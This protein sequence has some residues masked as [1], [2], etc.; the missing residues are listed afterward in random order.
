MFDHIAIAP[1]DLAVLMAYLVAVVLFGLWVG[2]G[3]Q[4]A[5]GYLLGGRNLPWWLL[6]GS[7]VATETSTATFLS[8]PGL[9]FAAPAAK[10][11]ALDPA[12]GGDLRF[13]QLAF[14]MVI[15]RWLIVRLLLPGYFHHQLFTAYQVLET[16]FGSI[17]KVVASLIFLVARNVGDGLR[18]FLAAIVLA[19]VVAVPLPL[20]VVAVGLLTIVY[21]FFG[22]IKSVVWNDC[23]QF[24]V[25]VTG[26]I[27]AV[28]VVLTRLPGGCEQLLSFAESAGKLRLIDG[29]SSL[30]VP[31]TI[32]AGLIGGAFLSL[33]THGTDQIMVQRYL[34]AR[35]QRQAGRALLLSGL[36]VVAQFALFLLLGVA[37]AAY[38]HQFPPAA[39]FDRGD[40][41]LTA[42]IVD[43]MPA[44]VGLIGIILA[45]VFSA[46]MSTLSSSLNSSAS[47]ALSDLLLPCLRQPLTDRQSLWS[48][49]LLTVFFGFVQIGIGWAGIYLAESV[50]EEVLAVAGF[51]AGL[52]LGLFLLG[53]FAPRARQTAA[54]S[55][56]LAGL[57]VLLY[58]RFQTDIAFTWYAVIGAVV[59]FV[60]GWGLGECLSDAISI[61][62]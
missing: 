37:L 38:Y 24:V 47:S 28:V 57:T 39:P 13:L 15:G 60:V 58:V 40:R 4:D 35:D 59:T 45:A 20:C 10:G 27:L 41:V 29:T 12:V 32:W 56:L 19:K 61:V 62:E 34:C 3:Q 5:T 23:V 44:G 16:R 33:G 48:S 26:G 53:I 17:T 11:G 21:T 49:R 8:V 43:E 2:R 22:G 54:L 42:F 46:A 25:Y 50:V 1:L 55:G 9:A 52:L 7:I 6:L 31:Y 51:T 14:G 30:S 18:L 36:V